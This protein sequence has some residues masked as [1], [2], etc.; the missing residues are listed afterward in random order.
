MFPIDTAAKAADLRDKSPAFL[1]GDGKRKVISRGGKRPF[2]GVQGKQA[3]FPKG[4]RLLSGFFEI[5]KKFWYDID[6]K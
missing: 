5:T 4:A 6:R 3:S 2:S 1:T